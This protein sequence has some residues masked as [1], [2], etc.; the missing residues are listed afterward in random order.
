MRRS[1]GPVDDPSPV[2]TPRAECEGCFTDTLCFRC[3]GDFAKLKL[4]AVADAARV[5]FSPAGEAVV[6][7]FWIHLV[8]LV[9][10]FHFGNGF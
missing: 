3:C 6:A 8:N 7:G 10:G 4:R 2:G 9:L 1:G 5:L